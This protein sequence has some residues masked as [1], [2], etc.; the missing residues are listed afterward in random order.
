MKCDK[1]INAERGRWKFDSV[2]ASEFDDHVKKSVPFYDQIQD[3]VCELSDW[4]I[5]DNAL[6]YDLGAATGTTIA[7]LQQHNK[8][9]NVRYVLIDY[10]KD[11]LGKAKENLKGLDNNHFLPCDISDAR[12]HD[13]S[14]VVCL[15]TL[16]FVKP[17]K[18]AAILEEVYR[19]LKDGGALLLVEKIYGSS[20]FIDSI[21]TEL[22][23]DLKRKQGLTPLEIENKAISL[24]GVLKPYTVKRNVEMLEAAGFKEIETFFRCWNFVG[25]IAIK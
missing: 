20:A 12:I 22:Y 16:H 24:R 14:L 21:Y 17:E 1:K 7:K 19:G 2:V 6:V 5:G 3:M 25:I 11:M 13:A 4:F 9:E 23:H 15:Y 18:R 8:H 10:S